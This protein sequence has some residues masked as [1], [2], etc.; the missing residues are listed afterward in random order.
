MI[1]RAQLQE[2]ASVTWR[3]SAERWRW[4]VVADGQKTHHGWADT[5]AEAWADVRE[6]LHRPHRQTHQRASRGLFSLPP[7]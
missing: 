1:D 6:V 4:T 2:R 7:A 3:E 5:E